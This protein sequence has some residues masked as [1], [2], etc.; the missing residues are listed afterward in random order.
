MATV[1]VGLCTNDNTTPVNNQ[2]ASFKAELEAQTGTHTYVVT[3]YEHDELAAAL[4]VEDVLVVDLK[5]LNADGG[6]GSYGDASAWFDGGLP[7]LV[8]GVGGAGATQYPA[9]LC[10]SL[11]AQYQGANGCYAPT[12]LD[13]AGILAAA[14]FAADDAVSVTTDGYAVYLGGT[15]AAGL[16][17]LFLT[18]TGD[19]IAGAILPAGGAPVGGGTVTNSIAYLS[20]REW[21]STPADALA[22]LDATMDYLYQ[23]SAGGGATVPDAPTALAATA[24][25]DD[26]I[27]LAWT[28]P[29][30]DGGAS[31]AGYKI[32]RESPI[33]GGWSTLVADTGTTGTSYSDTGLSPATEYNYR[34]S[35][36]NSEGAGAASTADD[37]TTDATILDLGTLEAEF[38]LEVDANW[39]HYI[40]IPLEAEFTLE[41][42]VDAVE[43]VLDMGEL[44]A[45]FALEAEAE[46]DTVITGLQAEFTLEASAVLGLADLGSGEDDIEATLASLAVT[47]VV[48]SLGGDGEAADAELASLDIV[49]VVANIQAVGTG[50]RDPA[51]DSVTETWGD[52]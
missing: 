35:A 36:I 16:V 7:C 25:G 44:T 49:P 42:D 30:S 33:G 15:L 6:G 38:A 14:G 41:A 20:P 37:A 21:S 51:D 9:P 5:G 46:W 13:S 2:S 32:E 26:Q 3:Y 4:A 43:T 45:E 40:D 31:I 28:A 52:G 17:T 12:P 22:I 19:F 10:G 11:T 18:N 48:Q 1:N 8:I 39:I 50:W 47:P 29:A 34:V 24:N 27:D 23:E